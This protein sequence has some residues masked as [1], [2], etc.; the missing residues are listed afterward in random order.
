MSKKIIIGTANFNKYYGIRKN[1]INKNQIN[2]LCNYAYRKKIYY[3]DTSSEYRNS[4]KIIKKLNSKVIINT[5]ILPDKNWIKFNY[6]LKK[7]IKLKKNL[8][9]KK[10]ITI[11][12]HDESLIYKNYFTKIYKNLI[13][14]KKNG[15]YKK[16]GIS[17]YNFETINFFIEKYKF[18]VIQ[19][20]FNIIDQRLVRQ[21]YYKIL[22]K[23]KIE[24][25]VRSIFLQGLLLNDFN[26]KDRKFRKLQEKIVLLKDYANLKNINVLDL[27][28]SFINFHKINKFVIGFND[29]KNFK[30]VLN[31]KKVNIINF[32]QFY[33]PE[34]KLIDPRY[35]NY[36]KKK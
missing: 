30:E 28:M 15:Y 23:K 7:I 21:N 1:K 8:G 11:Y 3:M 32:M 16:I 19:C 31:Y 12:L 17:I 26:F 5:K 20:P 25:H 35:W 24:I 33:L 9:N 14:L 13:Q 34:K 2:A 36:E 6:C 27:C 4:N 29:L 18:D 10:I 22:K